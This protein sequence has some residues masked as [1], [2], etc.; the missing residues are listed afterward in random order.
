[1][2]GLLRGEGVEVR[3]QT[4][5]YEDFLAADEIFSTGNYA[6]VSPMTR[7]E[8]RELPIG[9]VFRRARALYWAFAHDG[10]TVAAA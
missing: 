6:K 5:M 8:Q 4:L 3:E 2:I 1:V 9:P 7:I 10:R